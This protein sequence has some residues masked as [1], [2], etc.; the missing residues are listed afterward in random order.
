MMFVILIAA[1]GL[2]LSGL[3]VIAYGILVQLST[4]NAL[5]I[6]GAISFCSG[7][8][9][10]GFW[11]TIRELRSISRK[12]VNG[13]SEVRNAATADARDAAAASDLDAGFPAVDSPPAGG[14]FQP[15]A[16]PPWQNETV[17]R[18]HPIPD[19]LHPEPEPAQKQKRNLLF[20]S[21]RRER[22]R[23]GEPLTPEL[24]ASE[25]RPKPMQPAEPLSF[26]D[27]WNRPERTKRSES[28]LPRRNARGFA[29]AAEAGEPDDQ[30]A[31]KILKSGIVDGMAYSLFSDG[32]IE[33]QMPEGMMRF[34]SIDELR[35]HLDQR[36]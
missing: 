7:A 1:I 3:L 4:G 31:A 18:D 8:I 2:A 35:V 29:S 5:I 27:D 23:G 36:S 24:L 13:V 34:S 11:T 21:T 14:L 22:A 20:S 17:L 9:M 30:P 33:A 10:L 6:A 25:L 28:P 19:P 15:A 12:L 16:P 26:D 32:S